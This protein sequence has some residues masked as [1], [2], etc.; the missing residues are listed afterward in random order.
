MLPSPVL[1]LSEWELQKLERQIP[2]P[3]TSLCAL[4]S[5]MQGLGMHVVS[6]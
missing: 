3:V 6:G 4:C 1:S 2:K 5:V